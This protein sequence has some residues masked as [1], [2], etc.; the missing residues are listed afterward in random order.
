MFY[1]QFRIWLLRTRLG[2]KDDATR[3]LKAYIQQRQGEDGHEW[4]LCIAR[5]LVGDLTESDFIA[6]APKTAVHTTDE[7]GPSLRGLLVTAA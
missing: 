5:F 1:C 6:Q 2:Q 7:I 4:E 3:E